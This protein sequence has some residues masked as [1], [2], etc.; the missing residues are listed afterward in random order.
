MLKNKLITIILLYVFWVSAIFPVYGTGVVSDSNIK[1]NRTYWKRMRKEKEKSAYSPKKIPEMQIETAFSTCTLHEAL[2]E[3]GFTFDLPYQSKLSISGQKSIGIKYGFVNYNDKDEG[4]KRGTPAGVTKGF[5]MTQE[6]QVKIKGK[7]GRKISVD[8]DYNDQTTNKRDISVVY[9]G[10]KKGDI[11]DDYGAVAENDEVIEEIAFGDINLSLPSTEFVGYNKNLFGLRFK[12]K[13]NKLGMMGIASRTKGITETKRFSG[14]TTFEKKDMFDTSYMRRKHYSLRFGNIEPDGNIENIKVYI[15][16]RNGNNNYSGAERA[17][18][19]YINGSLASDATYYFDLQYPGRDY[20]IDFAKNIISFKTTIDPGYIIA[21]NYKKKGDSAWFANGSENDCVLLKDAPETAQ[22]AG[23]QEQK[24]YYYLGNRKII[25]GTL[26]RDF[27]VKI[28]DQ[29]RDAV[30][31]WENIYDKVN[32][33]FDTGIMDFVSDKPFSTDYPDIYDVN[34]AKHHYII[35]T[36][37]YHRIKTFNVRPNLVIGSE[38]IEIDGNVLARDVDYII[39]YDIGFITFMNEGSIGKDSKITVTYEYMPFGGQYQQT[40]VG[41]RTT[42]DLPH[43]GF[44]GAT[45]IDNRSSKS[46]AIPQIRST[47][48]SVT[49]ID[50]D[51]MINLEPR[52]MPIK[53]TLRGEIAKSWQDPNIEGKALIDNMEGIKFE[54]N[55]PMNGDSWRIARTLSG[56]SPNTTHIT[57]DDEEI[58][59]SDINPNL[60]DNEKK[61]QVLKV[62]YS[63]EAGEEAAIMYPISNIGSD[64]SQKEFMELAIYGD[65]KGEDVF[66]DYGVIPEDV[67]Q[68]NVLDTEDV[69]HDGTLNRGEDI[70]WEYNPLNE[71]Y[72]RIRPDNGEIDTEDLDGDSILS[73]GDPLMGS[74]YGTNGS[75]LNTIVAENGQTFDGVSW[76]GWKQFITPMNITA[77]NSNNWVAIKHVRLTIKNTTGFAINGEIKLAGLRSVNTNWEKP[78]ITPATSAGTMRVQAVNEKINSNYTDK[79]EDIKKTLAE[80][81][82]KGKLYEDEDEQALLL[83]YENLAPG[84]NGYTLYQFGRAQDFSAYRRLV[85]FVYGDNSGENM[86]MKVG[87]GESNYFIWDTTVTW[88]GWKTIEIELEDKDLDG[89]PDGFTGYKGAPRLT[90][91]TD[92]RIGVGNYTNFTI[93]KGELMIN[94]IYLED[95]KRKEGIAY[96]TAADISLPG[97]MDVSGHY[98]HID[99]DFEKITTGT[100]EGEL[101]GTSSIT[102][103]R[104]EDAYGANMLFNRISFMPLNA[105]YIKSES[106][107][108]DAQKT[109]AS[110]EEEGLVRSESGKVGGSLKLKYLP[111]FTGT[112]L[113]SIDETERLNRKDETES[114]TSGFSYSVPRRFLLLPGFIR[115]FL[116]QNVSGSYGH[117]NKWTEYGVFRATTPTRGYEALLE[118]TDNYNAETQFNVPWLLTLNPSAGYTKT[119]ERKSLMSGDMNYYDKSADYSASVTSRILLLERWFNPSVSYQMSVGEDYNYTQDM[120]T[121]TGRVELTTKNISRESR[122]AVNASLSVKKFLPWRWCSPVSSLNFSG[123]YN[124]DDSDRWDNVDKDYIVWDKFFIRNVHGVD[125]FNNKYNRVSKSLRDTV[126]LT[127]KWQPLAFLNLQNKLSPISTLDTTV[128]YSKIDDM[129]EV[130]GTVEETQTIVYPDVLASMDEIEKM[131]FLSKYITNGKV[132]GKYLFKTIETFRISMKDQYNTGGSYRFNL[133]SRFEISLD[134]NK[135]WDKDFDIIQQK[136]T[137]NGNAM[138]RS[139]QVGMQ[140]GPW[141]ITPKYGESFSEE[142]N[143]NQ[144]LTQDITTRSASIQTRADFALPTAV[145]LPLTRIYLK[146]DNRLIIDSTIKADFKRS[147]LNVETDNENRYSWSTDVDYEASKNVKTKIGATF[148]YAHYPEFDKGDFWAFALSVNV[149]IIF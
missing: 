100:S 54:D 107:I 147:S 85:F 14:N 31:G 4:E 34:S 7:V 35:Y 90:N 51:T 53:T 8:V 24:N 67:D 96:K 132:S 145:K 12:A 118:T 69:N 89:F 44:I 2:Q 22:V 84:D 144:E 6:L 94:D 133:F 140:Y 122:G 130:T 148:T 111:V 57:W 61:E 87:A 13:Y 116:P 113:R 41:L 26:G 40:L 142:R 9:R 105:E 112:A 60:D 117:S 98:K 92:V 82:Y 59:A 81:L 75:G 16:D 108:P 21:I 10:D 124:L 102:S 128:N 138:S 18:L 66:I 120:S 65:N 28:I 149:S 97:W 121:E 136:I 76:S 72:A 42:Y 101:V 77:A 38:R 80:K 5:D 110:I 36:E 71:P 1:L 27:I 99:A 73:N 93:T 49:I 58:P 119:K 43:D 19:K 115:S 45:V 3:E 114:Y 79:L 86:Y 56:V 127:G 64:Y 103:G 95:V 143:I 91:I 125:E 104:E 52:W 137:R 83:E 32:I 146:F 46:A 88:T 47:P 109:N 55:V 74:S 33:D 63:L 23:A 39:D 131:L 29:N 50:A 129:K 30:P 139:M 78:I 48:K 134:Y 123:S 17:A 37:Y 126:R 135:S 11:I 20:T 141:R 62:G 15:D 68:D 25:K 106:N 70:G